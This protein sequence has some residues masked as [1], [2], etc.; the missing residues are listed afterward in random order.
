M[1]VSILAIAAIA[2][3]LLS[4]V[5]EAKSSR[6]TVIIAPR[7]LS[8]GTLASPHEYRGVVPQADARFQ[9][10]TNSVGGRFS[11]WQ[12]DPWLVPYQR[13]SFSMDFD[14]WSGNRHYHGY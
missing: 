1:R 10:L 4:S 12:Q 11:E 9:P 5:A 14:G 6:T 8:A 7:Y 13:S 2:C 3:G